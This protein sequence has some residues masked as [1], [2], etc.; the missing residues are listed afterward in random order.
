MQHHQL[1]TENSIERRVQLSVAIQEPDSFGL[2]SVDWVDMQFLKRGNHL[3]TYDLRLFRVDWGI[4]ALFL[5]RRRHRETSGERSDVEM[6]QNVV[7]DPD[8]VGLIWAVVGMFRMIRGHPVG[9]VLCV[10]MGK[11]VGPEDQIAK[12]EDLYVRQLLTMRV[13]E[14]VFGI[15]GR[16][17]DNFKGTR[18]LLDDGEVEL[19]GLLHSLELCFRAACFDTERN[20]R[21]SDFVSEGWLEAILFKFTTRIDHL[22]VGAKANATRGVERAW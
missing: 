1:V 5:V 12:R 22:T 9:K 10:E 6:F 7:F 14:L 8:T 20:D 21:T 19:A 16:D 11:H 18:E 4:T 3:G 13:T 17:G 15:S 2:S